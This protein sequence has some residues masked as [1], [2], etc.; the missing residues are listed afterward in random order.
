MNPIEFSQEKKAWQERKKE[1]KKWGN[2]AIK[3]YREKQKIYLKRLNDLRVRVSPA[4]GI[5]RWLE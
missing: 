2:R 1:L 3:R 5:D 4:H